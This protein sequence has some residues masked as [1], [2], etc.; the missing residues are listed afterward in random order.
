MKNVVAMLCDEEIFDGEVLF[1]IL[2]VVK[3]RVG[4][5][6]GEALTMTGS[7]ELNEKYGYR[8][9]ERFSLIYRKESSVD[10]SEHSAHGHLI[11]RR[12]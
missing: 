12:R 8:R 10:V 5:V 9:E 6:A 2:G 7:D 11:K 4:V 1:K 3:R